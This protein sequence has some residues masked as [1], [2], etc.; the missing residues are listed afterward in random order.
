MGGHDGVLLQN[1][2]LSCRSLNCKR[3]L[4]ICS[5]EMKHRFDPTDHTEFFL[6]DND[7]FHS[8]FKRND[9]NGRHNRT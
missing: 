7:F 9:R 6:A 5:D 1:Y 8:Y 4:T 3:A 2:Q